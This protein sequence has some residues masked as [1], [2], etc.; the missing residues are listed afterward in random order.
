MNMQFK[1]NIRGA[2]LA[3]AA[4]QATTIRTKAEAIRAQAAIRRTQEALQ[5][6]LQEAARRAP[7]Q[8]QAP[9]QEVLAQIARAQVVP[10]PTQLL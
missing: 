2:Q 8:V 5:E 1:M 6:A 7:A 10:V 9:A 4:V 3:R